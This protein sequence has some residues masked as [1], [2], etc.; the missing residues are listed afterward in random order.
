MDNMGVYEL[1]DRYLSFDLTLK[2]MAEVENLIQSDPFYNTEFKFQADL[3]DSL[4]EKEIMN[5][6]ENL[7]SI[8]SAGQTETSD[9]TSFTLL[10]D[11][12][13]GNFPDNLIDTKIFVNF[14][15]PLPRIHL[16]NHNQALKE[17]VHRLYR[18][19]ETENE[20]ENELAREALNNSLL[21]R[22]G[23]AIVDKEVISVSEDVQDNSF[24][25]EKLN[26]SNVDIENEVDVA[27]GETDI[28]ELREKLQIIRQN[29][30]AKEDNE[31]IL[32]PAT[33]RNIR[34]IMT[35]AAA[36]IL[37][38]I[39]IGS[40]INNMP[41]QKQELFGSSFVPY[42]SNSVS[43]SASDDIQLGKEAFQFYDKKSYEKAISEFQLILIKSDK[44]VYHFFI[45][46]SYRALGENRNAIE[47]YKKVINDNNNRFV[48]VAEWNLCRCYTEAGDVQRA[49]AQLSVI[50]D[51]KS[52]YSKDA[53]AILR[54]MK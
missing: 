36:V 4:T 43:R 15:S 54:K 34:R 11:S 44:P 21:N 45:G 18:L 12:N 5:L 25:N 48:E 26:F 2:E 1:I 27:I 29:L 7:V 49:R 16:I 10:Q 20:A 37:L 32:R 23:E 3:H 35:S 13:S 42:P 53:K 8:I 39:G 38:V 14:Y 31:V 9:E 50:A 30:H 46:E 40:V 19:N 22:I 24:F 52:Y 28:M 17:N 47:E 6:R 33:S 51:K 41:G